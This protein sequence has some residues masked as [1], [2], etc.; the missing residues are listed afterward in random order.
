VFFWK[1]LVHFA[2]RQFGS[3]FFWK[4][5]GSVPFRIVVAVVAVRASTLSDA[6]GPF[7]E[8]AVRI[9]ILLN[10]I[11]VSILSGRSSS[12]TS[13]SGQYS[14]GGSCPI[15]FCGVAVRTSILLKAIRV[16]ILAGRS[17][18]STGSFDQ[19]S[20]GISWRILQSSSSDQYSFGGSW[21]QYSFRSY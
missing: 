11:R 15:P 14:F 5:F 7:C 17:S 19:Y 9:N 20:F 4:K 12:S 21:D 18:S 2:E 1:Q 13:S 3:L 16:G 8:V 10:A 6:V